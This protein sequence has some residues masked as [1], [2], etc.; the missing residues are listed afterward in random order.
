MPLG[1]H[2]N[3]TILIGD[4]KVSRPIY[5]NL[6]MAEDILRGF[7]LPLCAQIFVTG[8]RNYCKI[9]SDEEIA[10]VRKLTD[11]GATIIIHGAYVDVPWNGSIPSVANIKKELE[12][13]QRMGA[14]GVIIHLGKCDDHLAVLD[15]CTDGAPAGETLWLEINAAKPSDHTFETPEKIR[16]L[17]ERI[18]STVNGVRLGL[19]IDTAHLYACGVLLRDHDAAW[20]WIHELP[21]DIPTALHLNDSLAPGLGSGKDIHAPLGAGYIWQDNLD[22]LKVVVGWATEKNLITIL[23]RPL[24][25]VPGDIALVQSLGGFPG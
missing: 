7:G 13:S 18:G 11:A 16:R 22:G 4:K 1:F 14:A 25:R 24:D 21:G 12:I 9:V 3:K 10:A 19:C 20:N 5:E 2:V 8:P 6:Y 17:F 23:E 15:R